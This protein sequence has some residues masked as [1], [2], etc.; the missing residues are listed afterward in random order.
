MHTHTRTRS[1]ACTPQKS[2]A[3]QDSRTLVGQ[4]ELASSSVSEGLAPQ[5][6]DGWEEVDRLSNHVAV[7]QDELAGV[8]GD[9]RRAGVYE[10]KLVRR[11]V[12][13]RCWLQIAHED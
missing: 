7:L 3:R 13:P 5:A 11:A 1:K 10:V 9:K 8:S 4:D 6:S 12:S 2:N